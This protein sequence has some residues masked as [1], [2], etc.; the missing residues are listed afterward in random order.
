VHLDRVPRRYTV[1]AGKQLDDTWDTRRD[2]GRYQLQVIGPNG[3]AR[4]FEGTLHVDDPGDPPIPQVTLVYHAGAGELELIAEN[5]GVRACRLRVT[6]SVYRRDSRFSLELPSGFE[7]VSRRWSIDNNG[8]WY[9]F[10]VSCDQLP[11]WSRRFAGRM[12]NGTDG[13]SDPALSRPRRWPR[14]W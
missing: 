6:P 4:G 13:I 9:D 2:R 8:N 12:E 7:P 3:F 5:L 10:R 14:M 1:E 11:D